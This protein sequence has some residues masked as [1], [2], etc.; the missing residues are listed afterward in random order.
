MTGRRE[1][2]GKGRD[3]ERGNVRVFSQNAEFIILK[4]L[5]GACPALLT[6]FTG[7]LLVQH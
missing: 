4:A 1:E 5:V 6:P 2:T 7:V 3:R